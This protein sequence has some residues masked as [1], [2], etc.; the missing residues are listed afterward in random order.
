M[1]SRSRRIALSIGAV[2]VVVVSAVV[3]AIAVGGSSENADDA[4]P[5]NTATVQRTDL[6]VTEELAGT[7]GY[8]DAEVIAFRTSEEGVETVPGG[9][10]GIITGAPDQGSIVQAGEV[11]YEVNGRP[12]VVLYAE[13]PV[14]RPLDSRTSDGEDVLYLERSLVDLGYDPDGEITVDEDF[15]AATADAIERLQEEIGADVDGG[16]D[17]GEMLFAEGPTYVAESLVGEGDQVQF[18]QPIVAVS[19]APSGTFTDL[20]AEGS[21][22]GQ[23]D[24]LYRTDNRPTLLVLG[25]TP[26]YRSIGIGAVGTDV[27]QL[28]QALTDLGFA[29]DELTAGEFDEAMLAAVLSWQTAVGAHPDGVV[30]IGEVVFLPAPIRV[31]D[32][33]AA[34]G[35]PAVAGTPVL[36]TSASSTFVTVQLATSDR[37]LVEVGDAVEVELPDES[38]TAATVTSIGTVAQS[39]AQG[40]SYFEM[41]VTLDDPN[42]AIGLDEAPVDVFV[43]TDSSEDA[44]AVPVTALLALSEGGYAVEI[45]EGAVTRLVAVETGLF[46]DGLVEIAGNVQAGDLVVVP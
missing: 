31:G 2:A 1:S 5:A 30:N 23:G 13:I 27:V 21:I 37:G 45:V 6:V 42:A 4:D 33:L 3:I 11:L 15:D 40:D 14:Y 17:L 39:T 28:Q 19:A 16:F 44:L 32:R 29:G 46:A 10:A 22:V 24:V 34:L 18:G 8:G 35:D 12:V 9:L 20:A 36:S 25:E 7:L 43:I 38:I 26:V 41:V